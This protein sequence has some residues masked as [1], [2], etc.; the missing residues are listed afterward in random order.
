M[1]AILLFHIP[2]A[3]RGT[4]C[5]FYADMDTQSKMNFKIAAPF[6]GNI[7]PDFSAWSFFLSATFDIFLFGK[8]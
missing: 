3:W 1:P 4:L 2:T 5:V 6:I 7:V 8:Q